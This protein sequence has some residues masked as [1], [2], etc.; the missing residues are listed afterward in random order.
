MRP[1]LF[2]CYINDL[3][4]CSKVFFSVLFAD[5]SNFILSHPDPEILEALVNNQ[6]SMIKDYFD[7]NGLSISIPKTTYIHF[8][9][10]NKKKHNLSI[11]I[12]NDELKE[13]E[14]IVFLGVTID[15][16]LSFQG[17]FEKVYQKAKKGLNG[18]LIVKNTLNVRA[19]L[20][21]YFSLVHS[22]LVYGGLIWLSSLKSKQINVLKSV[23]K[24]ALRAI[25]NVKYNAHTSKLF[26]QSKVT[27]I[28]NVF[29]KESILLTHKYLNLSLPKEIIKIF[30]DSLQNTAIH[31]RSIAKSNLKIKRD[32]TKG[33]LMFVTNWNNCPMSIRENES[34]KDVK[35]MILAKQNEIEVCQKN[36]CYVCSK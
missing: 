22:H 20:Q 23:Q 5:D 28:E 14:Q 32:L 24:K 35:K 21:I 33:N 1:R 30:D 25:Y 6:L 2:N 13:S 8:C 34:I 36:N 31:T 18:L 16:R 17:H 26:N 7:S 29:E 11:R 27:K 19:K 9:P 12:G 4:D 10:K 15:S 3:P